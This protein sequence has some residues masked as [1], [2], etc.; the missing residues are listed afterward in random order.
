MSQNEIIVGFKGMNIRFT[1]PFERHNSYGGLV[2]TTISITRTRQCFDFETRIWFRR[3]LAWF[4]D[5]RQITAVTQFRG[6]IFTTV[7]NRT[8]VYNELITQPR[9]RQ[10]QQRV[11]IPYWLFHVRTFSLP[12]NLRRCSL[13][14]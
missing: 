6:R 11:F 1:S 2:R 10:R 12:T 9:R 14:G 4:S 5:S 13:L 8:S 3:R 7:F